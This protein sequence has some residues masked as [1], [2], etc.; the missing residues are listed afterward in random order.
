[1]SKKIQNPDKLRT[2]IQLQQSKLKSLQVLDKELA[3]K[4]ERLSVQR[5][6]LR[7]KAQKLDYAMKQNQQ[8]LNSLGS[9]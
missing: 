5:Q 8:R 1:M 9:E 7:Q 6:A 3:A 4:I 2:E